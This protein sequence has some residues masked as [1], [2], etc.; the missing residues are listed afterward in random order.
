MACN[1]G[2]ETMRV[3]VVPESNDLMIDSYVM[4]DPAGR[5]FDNV[6]GTHVYSRP[7]IS[8]GVDAALREVSVDTDKFRLRDN[9]YDWCG[10][11]GRYECRSCRLRPQLVP[12]V[13]GRRR[14]R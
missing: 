10:G 8:V 2:A 1:Q 11:P 9:V 3:A 12:P 6:A 5:F 14:W 7:A 4:V 13:A